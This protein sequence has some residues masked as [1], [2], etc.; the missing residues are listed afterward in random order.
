MHQQ[1]LCDLEKNHKEGKSVGETVERFTPLMKLYK[2]YLN[3]YPAMLQ[4]LGKEKKLK[5][6]HKLLEQVR[7]SSF[8]QMAIP[9]YL[10]QVLPLST[11][12]CK[13]QST[14]CHFC[15]SSLFSV[16]QDTFFF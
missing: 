10:I 16:F 2:V 8:K 1:F 7:S 14:H 4:A 9:S 3:G 11:S 12:H 15:L 6:F 13:L 5:K